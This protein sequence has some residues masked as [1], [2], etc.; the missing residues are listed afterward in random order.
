MGGQSDQPV[1]LD[2]IPGVR[3]KGPTIEQQSATT[4]EASGGRCG[5]TDPDRVESERWLVANN[6]TIGVRSPVN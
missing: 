2:L 4:S 5:L 1:A 6:R 3:E